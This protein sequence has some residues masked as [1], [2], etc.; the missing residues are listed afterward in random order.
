MTT[1]LMET[2]ARAIYNSTTAVSNV[3]TQL[4][5]VAAG[6][7]PPVILSNTSYLP[8]QQQYGDGSAWYYH[9]QPISDCHCQLDWGPFANSTLDRAGFSYE[10][11]EYAGAIVFGTWVFSTWILLTVVAPTQP[12][13]LTKEGAE[14]IK[15]H[16]YVGIPYTHLEEAHN[17]AWTAC[18]KACPMTCAPNL[19]TLVAMFHGFICFG[20]MWFYSPSYTET[21][22]FWVFFV[23]A[24][25]IWNYQTLD[26][27][28]GKQA[29]RTGAGSPLGQLFD[30]G[31]DACVTICLH[32]VAMGM[33][34]PGPNN[35]TVALQMS[36][37]L[38]FFLAQWNEYTTHVLTIAVGPK[39]KT[40]WF[41]A[42]E[43]QYVV[44]DETETT[45][46][47]S[48]QRTLLFHS[49]VA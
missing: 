16:K 29:R 33:M 5:P 34:T 48:T 36:T 46:A 45:A 13:V 40:P 8:Q 6:L 9:P 32:A 21:P 25:C 10:E 19:I 17:A 3:T 15:T 23:C 2:T 44:T 27:I 22:P 18:A 42:V 7:V 14:A 49:G 24:I 12:A 1:A 28:D 37:Q 11:W 30:H 47:A 26:A 31:C 41:G 38:V 39:G 4:C 43:V 35:W 20:L